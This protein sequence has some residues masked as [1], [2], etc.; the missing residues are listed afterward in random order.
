MS[1]GEQSRDG[2]WFIASGP[3]NYSTLGSTCNACR[4]CVS[5]S[6]V[7]LTKGVT[8]GQ[9]K[10][11]LH[12]DLFIPARESVKFPARHDIAE[13]TWF[14][15]LRMSRGVSCPCLMFIPLINES[16]RLLQGMEDQVF[17]S[18]YRVTQHFLNFSRAFEQQQ[19]QQRPEESWRLFEWQSSSVDCKGSCC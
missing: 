18:K 4:R 11:K 14:S 12:L 17:R 2:T 13:P 9:H 1:L 3:V 6:G 15:K 7:D 19:Q 10:N 8:T 16:N 5:S